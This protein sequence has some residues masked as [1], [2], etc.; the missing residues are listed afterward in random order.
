LVN[1][2]KPKPKHPPP[3]PLKH[4]T[5]HAPLFNKNQNQKLNQNKNQTKGEYIAVEKLEA[6]YAKAQPVEQVWV[7]GDSYQPK[8]VAVVVPKRAELEAWA[9]SAGVKA[10][11]DGDYAALCAAPAAAKWVLG[12]LLAAAKADKL[13][14][15][16]RVAAVHLEPEPFGVEADLMT[17][18]FK[19]K[20]PQLKKRY[21]GQ[22]DAMY[23]ALE[24]APAAGGAAAAAAPAAL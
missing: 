15:F 2:Y 11:A 17:P 21:Q 12:E 22:I 24:A 10:G 20:R 9:A 23:A 6:T 13:K 5:L 18:T 1:A 3:H 4:K 19:L 16:E 14:G 7:Y 8:L